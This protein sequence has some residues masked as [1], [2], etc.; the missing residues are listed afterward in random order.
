MRSA[1]GIGLMLSLAACLLGGCG[2][3]EYVPP[4]GYKTNLNGIEIEIL[5]GGEPGTQ[6]VEKSAS[7]GSVTAGDVKLELANKSSSVDGVQYN[8]L[9]N[10]KKYGKVFAGQDIVVGADGSVWVYSEKRDPQP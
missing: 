7:G 9:V 6:T 4:T 1:I 2:D 8:V 10:G 5:P 3:K